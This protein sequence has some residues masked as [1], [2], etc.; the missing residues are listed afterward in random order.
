MG[1]KDFGLRLVGQLG[2]AGSLLFGVGRRKAGR[3]IL[4]MDGKG[5]EEDAAEAS[6]CAEAHEEQLEWAKGES[7]S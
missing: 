1:A 5:K 3:S 6:E 2:L 4:G 7:N